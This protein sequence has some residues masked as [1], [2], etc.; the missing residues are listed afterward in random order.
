MLPGCWAREEV[1][2]GKRE[3]GQIVSSG[4]APGGTANSVG[5][6]LV[7]L[8]GHIR[9]VVPLGPSINASRLL[10]A[11]PTKRER[12][13][14]SVQPCSVCRA[15]SEACHTIPIYRICKKSLE[16]GSTDD[17]GCV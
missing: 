12:F 5:R 16:V 7:D 8:A 10:R 2:L 13:G 9:L 1:N 15:C 4:F 17:M 11:C 14:L 6:R 3:E